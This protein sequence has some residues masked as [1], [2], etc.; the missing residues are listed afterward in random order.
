MHRG[1]ELGRISARFVGMRLTLRGSRRDEG[2]REGEG[3]GEECES[4]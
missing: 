1:R 2:M 4:D 3:V